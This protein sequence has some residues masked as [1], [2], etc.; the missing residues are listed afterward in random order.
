MRTLCIGRGPGPKNV[1]VEHDGRRFVTT[2]R[3]WNRM[4]GAEM[5][6]FDEYVDLGSGG[7]YLKSDEKQELIE[8]GIAFTIVG[9][10]Y[11]GE[12]KYGP[13]YVAFCEIPNLETGEPE[14]RKIGFPVGSGA[15]SRDAMLRQMDEY[16]QGDGAQPV[17]VKL[18]KPNRAIVIVPAEK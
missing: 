14:E 11:D 1:L 4:K 17:N 9:L 8:N 15:D 16:L 7:S 13:R 2:Y 3:I 18:E 6:F 5:G 12:N 10:T